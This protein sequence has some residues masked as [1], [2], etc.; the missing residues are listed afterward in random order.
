MNY[1]KFTWEYQ[2]GGTVS[3]DNGY[4]TLSSSN[5]D[6]S[7]L[8]MD[9]GA[10]FNLNRNDDTTEN[11]LDRLQQLKTPLSIL[12]SFC[13]KNADGNYY[14]QNKKNTDQILNNLENSGY[15]DIVDGLTFS[16]LLIPHKISQILVKGYGRTFPIPVIMG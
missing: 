4:N 14:A 6:L 15:S 12:Q 8:E 1:S 2:Y 9:M 5:I 16:G 7:K 3:Y 10:D 13:Q 11:L